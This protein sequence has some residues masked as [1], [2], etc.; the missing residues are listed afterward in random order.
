M[1][2]TITTHFFILM[3]VTVVGQ[4]RQGSDGLYYDGQGKAFTGT[5]FEYYADSVIRASIEV[6]DGMPDGFTKIYF[7]NSQ[8]E[9]VRSFSKGLKHGKWEKW[10]R[11]NIKTAEAGYVDDKKEGKWYIWDEN[12]T[13][14]Y[15]MEYDKGNKT[16]T[17]LMFDEQGKLL[18][19]KKY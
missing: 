10:N 6:K 18:D 19:Q 9:E 7:E 3:V 2:R 4:V 8:P 13:L 17:W 15:D 14:R 1:L 12:G 5:H 16:G 11:Q